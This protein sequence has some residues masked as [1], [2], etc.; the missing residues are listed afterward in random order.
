MTIS[1][2]FL[3]NIF[4]TKKKKKVREI[5]FA[6]YPSKQGVGLLGPTG[7]KWLTLE[8]A[9]SLLDR[10]LY[11]FA[12]FPAMPE[13]S[14]CPTPLPTLSIVSILNFAHCDIFLWLWAAFS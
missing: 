7:S 1:L 13:P 4:I 11:H 12:F 6:F 14:R 9:A 3:A 8:E 5:L 2:K 10:G